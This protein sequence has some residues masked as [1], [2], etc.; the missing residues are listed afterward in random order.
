MTTPD[1]EL[2]GH[3]RALFG[4]LDTEAGFDAR[5]MARLRAESQISA[6]E[7]ATW[8]RK[9]ERARYQRAVWELQSWRRSMLRL[10]T[11]DT[12]IALLLVVAVA[13]NWPHVSRE[14]A[15]IWH[16][17]SAYI[18]MLLAILIAAVPLLGIWAERTRRS[19]GP[20]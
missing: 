7:R 5:L 9:E 18:T 11:L 20:L 17:H 16:Q 1:S 2:D 6:T 3:L 12:G 14:V 19:I 13:A 15:G 10:L 4:D 8:A